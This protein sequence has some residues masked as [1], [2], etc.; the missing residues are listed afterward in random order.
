MS[1]ISST[2]VDLIDRAFAP[3]GR[4]TR[5]V[6]DRFDYVFETWFGAM[7]RLESILWALSF[8]MIVILVTIVTAQVATRYIFG[9]I[10]VWGGEM[11]RVL[12]I[13]A[14]LLLLPALL[15]GDKHLQV[16]FVFEKLPLR[17][18]RRIRS[19]QLIIITGFAYVYTYYGWDYAITSGY[20]SS[21]TSLHH[22]LKHLPLFDST[23][24][25][26]MFW[27][28]V[29]LPVSGVLLLVMCVSKL[30]QINYYPNQ[31]QEDYSERYGSVEM[32]D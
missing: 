2:A 23:F 31:L 22:F 20:R 17:M 24:R 28:Y 13:W 21:S 3:F 1:G 32:E 4:V 5:S 19:I 10:P 15:W 27:I 29:V 8:A 26:D 9:F 14:S 11:S 12:G 30:V 7:D 25:L 6:F 18:R 16:E